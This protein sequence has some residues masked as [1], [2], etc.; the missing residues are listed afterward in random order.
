MKI[1]LIPCV[2]TEWRGEGRLL[3][4][5][6]LT[7]G[8]EA[9][10]CCEQWAAGLAGA[11]L[12]QLFHAPDEL[13]TPTAQL[14]GRKLVIPTKAAEELA[15]VD[16]GL[17]AGLTDAQLKSRFSSAH[18]QL[19]EAPL[20]VSP[21]GGESL[22]HADDRLRAFLKKQVKRNGAGTVG[23]V[24]RPVSLAMTL[25]LL[26]GREPSALWETAKQ[27]ADPVVVKYP[28]NEATPSQA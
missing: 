28:V 3:G 8:P 11:G 1:A 10:N 14:L 7:P 21:P 22:G 19:R 2:P 24:M 17:W 5:V 16:I 6:E 9:E 18:R 15:E 4:R 25:C 23:L 13:S 26:D 12:Q 27:V 20:N